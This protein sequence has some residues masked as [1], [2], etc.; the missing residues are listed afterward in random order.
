MDALIVLANSAE[1]TST[2]TVSA[3][4]LG[5]SIT[6]TP[7][8][9]AAVILLINVP[10]D[11]TNLRHA[12]RLSLEDADGRDVMLGQTPAG[13]PAPLEIRA[14]FEVGRP[15]G[16]PHGTPLDQAM[17]ISIGPGLELAAGERYQWRLSIDDVEVAVRSFLVRRP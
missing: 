4:G 17:P 5:W 6:T 16:L 9:P 14:E 1:S 3:L 8:P 15:A 12:M 10:W 11:Q 2:G 13:E 7:T